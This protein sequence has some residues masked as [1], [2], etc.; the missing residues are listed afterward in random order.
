MHLL[1]VVTYQVKTSSH[2]NGFDVPFI[3]LKFVLPHAEHGVFYLVH[4]LSSSS[5]YSQGRPEFSI[6]LITLYTSL[7]SDV[8]PCDQTVSLLKAH[9]VIY[10]LN[11]G[12]YWETSEDKAS[13]W[14]VNMLLGGQ[15][16][17]QL[18]Q[19]LDLMVHTNNLSVLVNVNSFPQSGCFCFVWTA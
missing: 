5:W 16:I 13:T 10:F 19:K 6:F 7:F 14:R 15:E 12:G 3:R 18:L 9:L 11:P 4:L 1:E 17:W 2:V 8:Y